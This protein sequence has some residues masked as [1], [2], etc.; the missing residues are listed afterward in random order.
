MSLEVTIVLL[1][2]GLAISG[3]MIWLERRP[4][5]SLDVRLFPTTPFLMIGIVMALVALVHLLS[6]F[7]KH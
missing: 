7:G 3:A 4:R 1:A 2:A 6:W 5:K